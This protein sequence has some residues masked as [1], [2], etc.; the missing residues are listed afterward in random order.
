MANIAKKMLQ[1]V[2]NCR[3]NDKTANNE[4]NSKNR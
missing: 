1:M 2:K 3:T 4:Q